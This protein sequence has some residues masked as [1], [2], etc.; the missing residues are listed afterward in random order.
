MSADLTYDVSGGIAVMTLNRPEKMNAL[1]PDMTARIGTLSDEVEADDAVSVL[2]LAAAGDQ[3]FCA[4]GDLADSVPMVSEQGLDAVIPDRRSRFFSGVTKPIIAAVNGIC[5]A[6][7]LE[8]ML[9]TDLRVAS[10]KATFGLPEPRWGLFPAGG[11]T[12]RLPD[13]LPWARAMELLLIGGMMKAEEALALG[14]INRVVEQDQ[15]LSTALDLAAKIKRNGPLAVRKIKES[16]LAARGLSWSEAFTRE[17]E[18]AEGVFR[19]E[20]AKEGLQAFAEKR[21]AV[22]KGR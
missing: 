13:Q 19:S 4:G 17:F 15:V 10:H 5:V 6:G 16:A 12:A 21:Q 9:G 20:D 1:T 18:L 3:A 8:L 14:L 7:G 2:I 11:S 22:F